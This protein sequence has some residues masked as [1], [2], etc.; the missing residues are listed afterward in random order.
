MR[1][2]HISV[3]PLVF[4]FIGALLFPVYAQ[5][6]IYTWENFES[7][8][9]PSNL[10]KSGEGSNNNVYVKSYEQLKDT[11]LGESRARNECGR[12]GLFFN[13]GPESQYLRVVSREK[14]DRAS[15][16]KTRKAIVQADFYF[17]ERTPQPL[18]I[19]VLAAEIDPRTPDVVSSFYRF[20]LNNF[21]ELYFSYLDGRKDQEPIK[22]IRE[23][24]NKY[25]L[26]IP[27]WH[28]FQMVFQENNKI[29]CYID[30]ME[31]NFS[32]VEEDSLKTLQMGVMIAAQPKQV[33][34]CLMDNLSIQVAEENLPLPQSPW[35][36]T[37]SGRPSPFDTQVPHIPSASL[38][39]L[40]WFTTSE[41]AVESNLQ[42]KLP[43]LVLFYSPF[44]TANASLNQIMSSDLSARNFLK[45][46]VLVYIDVNQLGGGSLAQKLDIFKV[47]CFVLLDF[48]GKEIT[49]VYFESDMSWLDIQKALNPAKG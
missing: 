45:Q 41:A 25:K 12:Y 34:N 1:K 26:E 32:P 31:L 10:Y 23:D 36:K 2:N 8:V 40:N 29:Y 43:Y 24:M 21:N 11:M 15:L 6:K 38:T 35:A 16:G 17:K 33:A 48:S 19:A 49:R 5:Y 14:L 30:G 37:T 9:F 27:G 18:G 4:I 20:G 3:F 42:K 22:Y 28:R 47:P 39:D 13:A 44:T 46:F 7:G